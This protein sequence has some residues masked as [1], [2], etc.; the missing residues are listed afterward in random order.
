[1]DSTPYP[2]LNGLLAEL[3]E[4]S[5]RT[6][7]DNLLGVYLVGSFATG[8]ADLQSDCDFL[9]V[10]TAP[11]SAE[12]E[13]AVRAF[14]SDIPSREGHWT[15]HLEG[16]YADADDLAS[17]ERIGAPWLFV[18]HG[19]HVM[20]WSDHCNREV[21]RW[22]LRERGVV[23]AGP[24]PATF[25]APVPGP[26]LSA[27]MRAELRTLTS[28]ILEWADLG[29]GWTQRYLV[30]TYCRVLY[31]LVTGSVTSKRAALLW[32]EE[33]LDSRWRPL[34]TQVREDRVLGLEPHPPRP[35]SLDETFAFAD[36]CRNWGLAS[37]EP[38]GN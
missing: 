1:V 4:H 5:C 22:S 15:G 3:V 36:W 6:F 27:R 23:L 35:G 20:V 29:H 19:H 7:A 26:I 24:D 37:V 17:L 8:D 31:T 32:A 30:T 38:P 12:Q 28:D 10:V 13:R 11:I 34:L 2:E 21:V 25:V 33:V 18:D 14:W 9:V 16:S